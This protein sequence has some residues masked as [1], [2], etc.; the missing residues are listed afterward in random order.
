MLCLTTV[1]SQPDGCSHSKLKAFSVGHTPAMGPME[2]V[3]TK[4]F[5]GWMGWDF[6]FFGMDGT[7][8]KLFV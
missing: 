5:M 8:Q 1:F 6:L 7:G 3:G 4:Y 2:L